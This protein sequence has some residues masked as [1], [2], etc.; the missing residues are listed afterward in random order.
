MFKIVTTLGSEM[1]ATLI[2]G[3]LVEAGIRCMP[4]RPELDRSAG[5]ERSVYVEEEDLDRARAVIQAE[6]GG[7]S[8]E[9]L[10]R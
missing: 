7:F 1:E 2:R 6:T 10:T 8:D 9:E 4:S 3:R 5:R